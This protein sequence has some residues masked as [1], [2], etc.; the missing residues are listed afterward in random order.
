[1]NA[2]LIATLAVLALALVPLVAVESDA[3]LQRNG[4]CTTGGFSDNGGGWLKINLKNDT[5]EAISVVIYVYPSGSAMDYLATTEGSVAAEASSEFTLEFSYD[6]SGERFV[7]VLVY[8]VNGEGNRTLVDAACEHSVRIDVSHSVWKNVS[9]YIV[10]AIIV[11]VIII[12]LVL[13]IR[14]SKKTK[15]DTAIADRAFTQMREE[16]LS[17]KGKIEPAKK[18]AEKQ[19]Y[20]SSG[21]KKRKSE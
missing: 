4:A 14:S 13:Y 21:N 15:A 2:K 12:V 5:A 9:T 10:I 17:K 8:K 7:D 16:K 18:T 1:M 6:S 3:D 20:K 19:T 11:I